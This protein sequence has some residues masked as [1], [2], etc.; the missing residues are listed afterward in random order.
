MDDDSEPVTSFLAKRKLNYPVVMGDEH[1]GLSYGGVLGL[2]VTFLIDRR[3]IIR[4]RYQGAT[5]L[6]AMETA[7]RKL[8]ERP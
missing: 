6:A 7:I 8:L 1:L 3:G 4:A 5:N 2:P